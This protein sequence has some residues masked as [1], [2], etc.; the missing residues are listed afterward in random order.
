MKTDEWEVRQRHIGRIVEI[1]SA[2]TE[3]IECD[4]KETIGTK[5]NELRE[6]LKDHKLMV[7]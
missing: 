4:W 1:F 2:L 7:E 6:Y 3:A 5:F